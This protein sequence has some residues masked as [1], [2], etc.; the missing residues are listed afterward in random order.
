MHSKWLLYFFSLIVCNF[1]NG[2]K[3]DISMVPGTVVAHSPQFSGKYIGSPSIAILPNGNYVASHDFFGPESNEHE[4]ATSR[5]YVSGNKGRSWIQI[6][7]I[8]DAFWSKLFVHHGDLF[9]LG[10]NKHHGNT[11]LRKSTDGGRTWTHP[12]DKKNGLLLTG[13]FHCAPGP[14]LIHNGRLWRAMESAMGTPKQWGKR[15]GNFMMSIPVEAD[16]LD[17]DNWI[18]SNILYRDSTYLNGNFNAWIEGNA[19]VDRKGQMWNILR[20]DD[21]T[22]MEEKAAFVKISSDGRTASFDPGTGFRSFPGGAKKFTVRYDNKSEKYWMIGNYIPDDIKKD[23][24]KMNPAKVR[25]T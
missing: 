4:S 21:K 9:F 15:Y 8:K 3:L 24:L 17:A 5:I 7:E 10:T 2:Q 16:L 12:T 23:N 18:F 6:A 25:N 1:V 19:V 14:I 20:V 13:E 11:L 22:T